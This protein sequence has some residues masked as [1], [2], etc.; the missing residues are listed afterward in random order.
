MAARAMVPAMKVVDDEEGEGGKAMA[1]VTRVAGERM[2]VATKRAMAMK[3]RE[4]SKEEGNGKGVKS[5]GGG[6]E[7]SGGNKD[8]DGIFSSFDF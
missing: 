8:D 2:A 3:T 4:A 1:M 5:N 7:E 6:K